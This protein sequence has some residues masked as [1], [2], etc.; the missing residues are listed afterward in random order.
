VI[1]R[2]RFFLTGFVMAPALQ[3]AYDLGLRPLMNNEISVEQ[4]F[5]RA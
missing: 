1:A 4:A 3:R 2:S 5:D